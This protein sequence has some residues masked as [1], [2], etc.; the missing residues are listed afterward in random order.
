MRNGLIVCGT[1]IEQNHHNQ[2]KQDHV[3]NSK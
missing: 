3:V 2:D 1:E